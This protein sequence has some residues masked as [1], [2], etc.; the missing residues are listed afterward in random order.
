M[1]VSRPFS[2]LL[3]GFTLLAASGVR[4]LSAQEVPAHKPLNPQKTVLLDLAN[5]KLILK[6]EV[7]LRD[8]ALEMLVCKKQ[9]KEHESILVVDSDA[10]VI[11]AG[12]LALG[13]KP[14]SP[15]RFRPR[16]QSATGTQID[17]FLSWKDDKGKTHRVPA[18][19]WV[20]HAIR[21]FYLEPMEKLPEG[22]TLPR[23]GD[24]R[25]EEAHKELVWYD[26]MTEKQRD[27]YLAMS[28]DAGW[29]KA[30]RKIYNEGRRREMKDRWV[31]AGSGFFVDPASGKKAYEAEGG[32]I[33]CV[34]NFSSAMIDVRGESSADGH[35]VVYEAYTPRIPPVKTKVAVEL[36]PR[37]KREAKP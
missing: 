34:A 6:A 23:R 29:Q 14:G 35:G 13:A 25:F 2:V 1:I 3:L 11:H 19:N 10:Y 16:F 7:C 18:Q 5:K 9:T 26:Q 28:N 32:E 12:L 17:V 4:S 27:R 33:I 15:A 24:L 22:V 36:V 8:G 20:Q 37:L 21:R 31:F 30:I